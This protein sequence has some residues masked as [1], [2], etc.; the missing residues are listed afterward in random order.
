M[1]SIFDLVPQFAVELFS[2]FWNKKFGNPDN[3]NRFFENKNVPEFYD[4]GTFFW[5]FFFTPR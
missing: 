5:K 3:K 4:S 1:I 2:G